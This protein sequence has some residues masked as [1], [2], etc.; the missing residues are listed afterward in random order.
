[1]L[2]FSWV[3]STINPFDS[4]WFAMTWHKILKAKDTPLSAWIKH[5][6]SFMER[7]SQHG[8]H[9]TKIDILR[10]DWYIPETWEMILLGMKKNEQAFIREVCIRSDHS[11]WLYARTV[12][13]RAILEGK[14]ELSHLENR[15]LGSVL[16][17]DPAIKRSPFEFIHTD[18]T[19]LWKDFP[20]TTIKDYSWTRRSL[21]SLYDNALLLT[22]IFMMDLKKLCM[23]K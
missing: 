5:A 14:Q 13:P 8:V 23:K 4:L 2:F 9:N 10:Q 22:E 1:M 7:L 19:K 3:Y 16:F 11:I 6:G 12:F 17:Q 20:P 21:F 18:P 15:P